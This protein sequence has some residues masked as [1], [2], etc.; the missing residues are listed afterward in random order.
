[1]QGADWKFWRSLAENKLS[2]GHP[3]LSSIPSRMKHFWLFWVSR[4]STAA[5]KCSLSA[6][7]NYR[8]VSTALLW[9]IGLR[10]GSRKQGD[11]QNL[12]PGRITG[13][14]W[15]GGT[16]LLR[17]EGKLSPSE[18]WWTDTVHSAEPRARP[19]CCLLCPACLGELNTP[20]KLPVRCFH[21]LQAAAAVFLSRHSSYPNN[22]GTSLHDQ[23]SSATTTFCW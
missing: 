18:L 4:G 20:D 17:A 11:G 21:V 5:S 12:L 10:G 9:N 13:G 1:M 15:G 23:P 7:Y 16:S 8:T 6:T 2:Q 22:P 19:C 3:K 14:I